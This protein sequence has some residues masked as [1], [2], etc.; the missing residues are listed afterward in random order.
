MVVAATISCSM[1]DVR[2]AYRPKTYGTVPVPKDVEILE[3]E[4]R[5]NGREVSEPADTNWYSWY[6]N[7]FEPAELAWWYPSNLYDNYDN[8]YNVDSAYSQ[9]RRNSDYDYDRRRASGRRRRY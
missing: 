4:Q 8:I 5:D 2:R 6:D 9:Y 1:A 3:T 7:V